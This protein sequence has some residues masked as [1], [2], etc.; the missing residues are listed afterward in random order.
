MERTT[1]VSMAALKR[2]I[3]I[4]ETAMGVK[5]AMETMEPMTTMTT[6]EIPTATGKNNKPNGLLT[7]YYFFLHLRV[8]VPLHN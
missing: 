5:A 3:E 8:H 6:M 7:N 2:A 1:M 4:T